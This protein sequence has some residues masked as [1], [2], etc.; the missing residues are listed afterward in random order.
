MDAAGAGPAP[1]WEQRYSEYI[2]EVSRKSLRAA[3]V[4]S[5]ATARDCAAARVRHVDIDLARQG[6]TCS[7]PN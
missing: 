4:I 6:H 7:D 1:A 2:V 5:L 3:D